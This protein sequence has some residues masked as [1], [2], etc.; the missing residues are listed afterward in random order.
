MSS[1]QELRNEAYKVL[2]ETQEGGNSASRIGNLYNGIIDFLGVLDERTVDPYYYDD[3]ALKDA[4]RRVNAAIAELDR[5]LEAA[6]ALA[7]QEKQR[8]DDLVNTIDSEINEKVE[9][10][11]NDAQ[12]LE[13]HAQGI[14]EAVNAGEILWKDEWD[15]NVEAYIKE[16]G[17]WYWTGDAIKTQWTEVVQSVS[18]ITSTVAEVQQDLAGRPTSTQ[19]TQISQ[20]VNGIEQSV[21]KLL[22]QGETTEALQSSINQS[23][24]DKVAS[25]KLET[26]YAQLQDMSDSKDIIK[27]MYSAFRNETGPEK[28]FNEIVSAGQSG[29][30]N[31]I[32]DIRTYV[33]EVKEGD[34]LKH[35]SI[36]SMEA[37]VNESITGLY[38]EALAGEA[39]SLMFSQVANNTDNIATI[40][41]HATG[42]YS[43]ADVATK[44]DNFR[45]GIVVKSE[46]DQAMASLLAA[47]EE[48]KSGIV[49]TAKIDEATTDIISQVGSMTSGFLLTAKLGEATAHMVATD[50]DSGATAAIVAKVNRS[51][52]EIMLSADQVTMTNAF[53][54]KITANQAFIGYL[55]GGS[56]TFTGTINANSLNLG[57]GVSIP[58][59]NI[60]GLSGA[61]DAK[62]NK[63]D[64]PKSITDLIGG[65]NVITNDNVI[66]G[67]T[68]TDSNGVKSRKITVGNTEYTEIINDDFVIFG[69]SKGS[70]S[71]GSRYFKIDSDGLLKA[72]NAIIYG[73]IYATNGEFTGTINASTIKG[74]ITVGEGDQKIYIKP[75]VNGAYLQAVNG[76]T[77]VLKLG[78]D[79]Y[80]GYLKL[81]SQNGYNY[82]E[83]INSTYGGYQSN[84]IRITNY[85]NT[86][87]YFGMSGTK[88]I[89]RARTNDSQSQGRTDIW[90]TSNDS[91]KGDV[92]LDSNG[93]LRVKLTE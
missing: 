21:N 13:A 16:V 74:N 56:A 4:I 58:Q 65:N 17:L 80:A 15:N 35:I 26:T 85:N 25:L 6:L 62:A 87:I 40:I 83:I 72:R 34:V 30:N 52:S 1:I 18:E 32:A 51:G 2:H 71:A 73:T 38:N 69:K 12:W 93:Y 45:S 39:R 79:N 29:F 88:F 60:S 28:S 42:D 22:Y 46:L 91:H 57:T 27:W 75:D 31:A 5:A 24:D 81:A 8:L 63:T 41:T 78:F 53:A 55:T 77:E 68:T 84:G 48:S 43:E 76:S 86:Q 7:N 23:I 10:M 89:F 49:V 67:S 59:G 3:T 44:F 66:V 14:Q 70:D 64:I 90:M 50:Q 37:K 11:L 54:N 92:Y 9:D 47:G 19:W 82:M 20:K 36:A 33:E 61:L